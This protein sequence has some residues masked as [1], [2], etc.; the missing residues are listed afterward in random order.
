MNPALVS[1]LYD[2]IGGAVGGA[3]A[4]LVITWIEK[5][6]DKRKYCQR[7]GR[8]WYCTWAEGHRGECSKYPEWWMELWLVLRGKDAR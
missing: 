1:I 5:A 7:P 2:V 8:G 4:L 6:Q 3:L